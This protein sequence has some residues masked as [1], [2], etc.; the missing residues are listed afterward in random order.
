MKQLLYALFVWQLVQL[1]DVY[2][3]TKT[4]CRLAI[5][6]KNNN[7]KT[8]LHHMEAKKPTVTVAVT[9]VGRDK[10]DVRELQFVATGQSSAGIEFYAWDFAYA[11]DKG[12]KP[13]VLIDKEGKQTY[14]FKAGFTTLP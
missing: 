7:N 14:K 11:A 1:S 2:L 8:I 5:L 13:Q 12:F 6:L 10:K 4:Y 3:K 9:E